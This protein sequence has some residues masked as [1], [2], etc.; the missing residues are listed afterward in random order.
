MPCS[1]TIGGPSP[2]QNVNV[3]APLR[4]VNNK[5]F[6]H[7]NLSRYVRMQLW[8]SFNRTGSV[9]FF[10]LILPGKFEVCYTVDHIAGIYSCNNFS[11]T[12][13]ADD[14]QNTVS[15]PR[16]CCLP[17]TEKVGGLFLG[18]SQYRTLTTAD[19]IEHKMP[20]S[21]GSRA[22]RHPVGMREAVRKDLE[23]TLPRY[24]GET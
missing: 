16:S 4:V 24:G 15:K 21:T 5:L 19:V 10:N 6:T 18:S 11:K 7:K 8:L 12:R 9:K 2:S 22:H 13:R 3:R 17:P 14:R 20:L 1:I 23:R